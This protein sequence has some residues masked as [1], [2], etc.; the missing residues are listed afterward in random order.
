MKRLHLRK[1]IPI[2]DL[3]SYMRRWEKKVPDVVKVY[4][5][6]KSGKWP[7]LCA[8]FTDPSVPMEEKEVAL[9][10][11]QHSGMEISGMTTLLSLGNFLVS[12]DERAKEILKKQVVLVVPCPNC[13][14]YATGDFNY[15]FKNEFGVD[16]YAGAF[17]DDLTVDS[18]KTPVAAALM[19]LVDKWKP[20]FMFDAH[21]VTFEEAIGIEILGCL[22]FSS[23]N[24]TYD[25]AFVDEVNRAQQEKGFAV[26][27]EDSSQTIFPTDPICYKDEY[28]MRFRGGVPRILLGSRAYIKYHTFS[29][30][31][32][33]A[34]EESG[35]T[36]I[37]KCLELG[38]KGYPVRTVLSP[39]LMNSLCVYGSNAKER[40][41][42]R[43]E[44]WPQINKLGI[45]ILYP[46]TCGS[47]GILV[48]KN[49]ETHTKLCG[50]ESMLN[51]DEFLNNM[52]AYGYNMKEVRAQLADEYHESMYLTY[53]G[54]G[55]NAAIKHGITIRL[56]LPYADA[57]ITG[58]WLNG[59]RQG[60]DNY[61]VVREK[62]WTY[63]DIKVAGEVPD[64]MFAFVKYD[65][66]DKPKGIVEFD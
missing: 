29:L 45:S 50:N 18:S 58:V 10:T 49:K 3:E 5:I 13:W 54:N 36:R 48:T 21:G 40:R 59:E 7:V 57:E 64:A 42:S 32:E 24:R 39:L 44:L 8:E 2:E 46:E 62:N 35:L 17:K 19:D 25:R 4:S 22:S 37:I 56:G 52:E 31:S 51:A 47:S 63:V 27:S 15:T 65:A 33:T 60:K 38:N 28:R 34:W 1:S 11:A 14:T 30:N 53:K 6:G 41:D 9:M 66:E 12:E 20:E 61:D 26:Y 16:E 55:E 43:V 23:I